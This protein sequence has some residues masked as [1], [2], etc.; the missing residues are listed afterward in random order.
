MRKAPSTPATTS[1]QQATLSKLRSTLSKQHSTLLPQTATMS[2]EYRKISSFRH[3][4]NKLNMFNLFGL[5]RKDEISFDNVA[6]TGNIVAKN[7]NNVEATFDIV[8]R[9]VKLVSFDNVVWTLLLVWTGLNAPQRRRR[10][11]A[12]AAVKGGKSAGKRK[13][14]QNRKHTTHCRQSRQIRSES[15]SQLTCTKNVV[16]FGPVV[17]KICERTDRQTDADRNTSHPSRGRSHQVKPNT[18][19][20]YRNSALLW[21]DELDAAFEF[22]SFVLGLA[23]VILRQQMVEPVEILLCVVIVHQFADTDQRHQLQSADIT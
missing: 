10:T 23:P 19:S 20:Q 15:R 17:F 2:N 16:K 14:P 5:C 6:E 8:E 7:G 3:S 4:R 9:I 13:H 18:I 21:S 22:V 11:N 1:K 12:F